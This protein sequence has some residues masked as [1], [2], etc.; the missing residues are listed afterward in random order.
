MKKEKKITV[1]F[2]LNTMLDAATGDKGQKY[3]PLYIQVTYNR[4]NMQ[5]KSKY[6]E[7][8]EKM[9][10]V[11]K[12]LM[13]FEEKMLCKVIRH[14]SSLISGEYDMKGLK[15][16]YEIYSGSVAEALENYLKPKLRLMILKTKDWLVP[17]LNFN[18]SR[19]TTGRL[20]QAASKLFP[21]LEWFMNVKLQEEL[22]AYSYYQRLYP[23]I[24]LSYTF[25]TLIE[26]AEGSYKKDLETKLKTTYKNKPEIIKKVTVLIEEAV[27]KNLK[28]LEN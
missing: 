24:F 25:P 4:K 2:Y 13:Q 3:Y 28:Q 12:E 5:L 21:D 22:E 20:Y 15:Q 17:V 7:Y 19:A 9:D 8:Y 14:E 1:K 10:K 26:W 27:A 18:D 16:K 23:E 11:N 6:G